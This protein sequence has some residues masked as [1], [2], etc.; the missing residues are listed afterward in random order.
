MKEVRFFYTPE[1]ESLQLPAD[2]AQHVLRVLRLGMGD[3]LN[4]MDGRGTFHRAVITEAGGH[5]CRYRI[6]ESVAQE[7]EWTGDIHVALAPTKNMDRVEWFAEKATE[8]G[9]DRLSLLN[10]RF[11]E[12]SV[13]KTS[14]L[15]KI[16]VAAMKQSHKAWLPMLDEMQPFR[17][18]IRRDDLPAQRFIAHCYAMTDIRAGE[19]EPTA[20]EKPFLLDVLQPRTS[21]L[22]LIGPEGDFSVDE[23]REAEAAGFR[24]ISLGSSRLRTETAALVAV[25]LMRLSN[26]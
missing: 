5:H 21:A 26:R 25:H 8:V 24:S 10:C 15:E 23:V 20:T 13:V 1:P 11:S 4:L 18:F 12:R 3:E 17:Q 6:L 7:K 16:L 2:E 22:V 14:R 9:M 19:A